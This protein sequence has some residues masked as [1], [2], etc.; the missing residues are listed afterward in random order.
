LLTVTCALCAPYHRHSSI[1]CVRS[2]ICLRT[3]AYLTG[4]LTFQVPYL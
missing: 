1:A 2:V 3:A 4:Y